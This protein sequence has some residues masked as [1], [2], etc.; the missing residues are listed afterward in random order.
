MMRR[1]ETDERYVGEVS[2]EL[3]QKGRFKNKEYLERTVEVIM[4]GIKQLEI[5]QDECLHI[6]SGYILSDARELLDSIGYTVVNKKIVGATQEF[7][8]KEFVKSLTRLGVGD[9]TPIASMRSFDSFLKWVLEDLKERERFV[10]TGWS[11][12]PRLREGVMAK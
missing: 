10:K 5:T 2:L 9:E 1:V 6:C 12:W 8:E 3:F 11:S 7:A 4:D